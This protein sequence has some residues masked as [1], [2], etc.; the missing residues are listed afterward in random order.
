MTIIHENLQVLYHKDTKTCRFIKLI[1]DIFY[2][3]TI[4]CSLI[5][6]RLN[7]NEPINIEYEAFDKSTYNGILFVPKGSYL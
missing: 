6:E 7:T 5:K 2:Y 4:I 1:C 3:I